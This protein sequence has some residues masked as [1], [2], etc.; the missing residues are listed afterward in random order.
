MLVKPSLRALEMPMA[1]RSNSAHADPT[2][3]ARL[4]QTAVLEGLTQSQITASSLRLYLDLPA[5]VRA[6]LRDIEALGSAE[7]HHN[8]MRAIART[9]VS[10]QYEVARRRGGEQMRLE[11][12]D[13]LETDEDILAEAVRAGLLQCSSLNRPGSRT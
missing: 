5:T 3:I 7:D 11:N 12:E 10:T 2:T 13:L 4:R 8:M 9:V 6:A 1:G